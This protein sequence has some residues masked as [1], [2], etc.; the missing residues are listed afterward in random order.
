[1]RFRRRSTEPSKYDP[2]TLETADH[3]LPYCIAAA[4]AEGRVTPDLF[5][6]QKILDPR[7]R[8]SLPKIKV[9]A[10]PEFEAAFPALQRCRVELDT[11][12]GKTF[13]IE[14]DY[15]YGDPRNPMSP[16]DMDAKF[17]ALCG[18][19]FSPDGRARLREAVARIAELSAAEF[20]EH[21]VFEQ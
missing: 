14:V 6:E 13:D 16:D 20:M 8:M 12:D 18:Q 21:L 9:V 2:R 15:P 11:N 19:D 5:D 4:L 17:D 10:N 3:S 7:I 1:M